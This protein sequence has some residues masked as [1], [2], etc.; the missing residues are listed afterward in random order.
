MQA[1]PHQSVSK[2][3]DKTPVM[4]ARADIQAMMSRVR[5]NTLVSRFRGNDA[6]EKIKYL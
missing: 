4:P 6:I 5:Q 1:E 2:R 3:G